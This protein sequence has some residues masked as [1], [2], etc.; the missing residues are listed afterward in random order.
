MD[1]TFATKMVDSDTIPVQIISKKLKLV[2]TA[3]LLTLSNTKS[4]TT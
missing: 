4:I 3:F 1:K 2:F